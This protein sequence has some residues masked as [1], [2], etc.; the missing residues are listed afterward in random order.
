MSEIEV[1]QGQ[2][3]TK[4]EE[5]KQKKL[6]NGEKISIDSDEKMVETMKRM[7][8]ENDKAL[9]QMKQVQDAQDQLDV[10]NLLEKNKKV[11]NEDPKP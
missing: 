11:K 8:P 4:I 1:V 7:Y 10:L 9:S 5:L 6:D 2:W 3:K